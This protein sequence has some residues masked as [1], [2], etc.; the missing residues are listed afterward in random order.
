MTAGTKKFLKVFYLLV[1]TMVLLLWL[2]QRSINAYWIQTYHQAS[3]LSMLDDDP[4]WHAGGDVT[5]F[6]NDHFDSIQTK[7]SVLD[8]DMIGFFNDRVIKD[9][10]PF[11]G[12]G[13]SESV[14][15]VINFDPFKT[16]SLPIFP[17]KPFLQFIMTKDREAKDPIV[18]NEGLLVVNKPIS[19]PI[20]HNNI[21]D[22]QRFLLEKG[23][24]VFFVGDSLMQGVA[25]YAM[26]ILLKEH[27]IESINLSKQSTG[28]SYPRFYN[29][30]QV[31]RDTF[32]KNADIKLMIVFMG[33][34]DPWDFP[35]VKG[36][37]FFRFNTVEWEGVYRTRIQ[38]L[39]NAATEHGAKVLWI[40]VPNMRDDKLNAG[41]AVLNRIYQSQVTIAKQ[42]YITSNDVLG[43]ADHQ[44]VKFMWMPN[45]GNVTVR[46]D[47]GIHFTVIGQKLIA[48]K[49]ISLLQ[50]NDTTETTK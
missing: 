16:T 7:V 31:V 9:N 38:Q 44:F 28:L 13:Y 14:E 48:D 15:L 29:W 43:M 24:K 50:F 8:D 12:R 49:I 37:R 17:Q 18:I 21:I 4:V 19:E 26:R 40:G 2:E 11:L 5:A 20:D 6:L 45:R 10:L 33:P 32:S 22:S 27:G 41:V 3:P 39:I 35:V 36:K 42:R 30:P 34:N 47:D 46:T 23:Q 25:P 1:I